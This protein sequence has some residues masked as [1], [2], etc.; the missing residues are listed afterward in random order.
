MD[1]FDENNDTGI[2]YVEE[3]GFIFQFK[4]KQEKIK[5]E[6]INTIIAYKKDLLT[7]DLVCIEIFYNNS[8]IIIT[9]EVLGWHHFVEQLRIVFPNI[10]INWYNDIIIPPFATN[11]T[12][13]YQKL[14]KDIP[15]HH[16]SNT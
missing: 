9:E 3:D 11:L 6:E 8:Q 14:D 2:V 12:I 7:V 4:A 16:P 10:P 15:D 1:V 5:W 13:L